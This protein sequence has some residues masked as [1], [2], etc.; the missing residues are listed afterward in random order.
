METPNINQL[1]RDGVALLPIIRTGGSLDRGQ[2]IYGYRAYEDLYVSVREGP[3][4]LLAYRSG[5]IS[6][7][8]VEKDRHEQ[9]DL[10]DKHAERV[11][12]LVTKLKAWEKQVGVGQSSGVQ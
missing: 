5:K 2:L 10:A 9:H 6:L 3:W 8:D 12:E 7:Y 1:V 4:K 11:Q